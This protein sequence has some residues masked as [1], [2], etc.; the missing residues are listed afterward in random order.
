MSQLN[1]Q[2]LAQ[3]RNLISLA[4][5]DLLSSHTP[6]KEREMRRLELLDLFKTI[7]ELELELP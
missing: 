5:V 6:N 4:I 3:I 1:K 2:Q 7:V